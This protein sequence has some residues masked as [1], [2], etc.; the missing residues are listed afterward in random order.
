M[1]GKTSLLRFS[2]LIFYCFI[3]I[4]LP[5]IFDIIGRRRPEEDVVKRPYESLY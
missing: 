4:L 5:D 2:I 3:Y 1:D